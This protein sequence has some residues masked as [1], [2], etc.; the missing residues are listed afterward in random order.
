MLGVSVIFSQIHLPAA[1]L[2]SGL[3]SRPA[4]PSRRQD[5]LSDFL[6]IDG[7]PLRVLIVEDEAMVASVLQDIVFAAG[8]D[9][10]ATIS[11]GLASVGAAGAI[12]PDIII[13]DI[14]LPGMDGIDAAA[15][16]RARYSLPVVFISGQ[17][18]G[19]EA[20]RR[21]GDLHRVEF[22]SKPIYAEALCAALLKAYA[23]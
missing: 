3:G 21:L 23:G 20:V 18:V 8:G 17:Q 14:G 22:L 13:M 16:I 1:R 15:I 7:K 19:A 11:S 5:E 4:G 6:R 10:A 9:V 2:T 12:R